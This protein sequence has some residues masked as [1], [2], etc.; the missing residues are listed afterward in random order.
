MAYHSDQLKHMVGQ[1]FNQRGEKMK[2]I[3]SLSL[4]IVLLAACN[5]LP[6]TPPTTPSTAAAFTR[7]PS[8]TYT[9]EPS[10][11]VLQEANGFPK[12][13][14]QTKR[15]GE[16][17]DN[18]IGLYLH[19]LPVGE[20]W[21]PTD[22]LNHEVFDLGVKRMK[23]AINELDIGMVK[24]STSEFQITPVQDELITSLANNGI[25]SSY[26]LSFWDKANHPT[27][28]TPVDSRFKT[29]TE[30]QRYLDFVRFIV[31]NVKG[32]VQYFEIWNEPDVGDL[33]QRIE[34]PEYINLVKHAIPV[35]HEEYPEAKIVISVAGTGDWASRD[36]LYKLIQSDEIMPLVDVV[37][38]H[39]FYDSSPEFETEYYYGYQDF[40]QYINNVA[41]NHGFRGEYWATEM[42]WRSPECSWCSADLPTYSNLV[43]AKYYARGIILNL[44]MDVTVGVGSMSAN[45]SSA[46][47][48][49]RNICTV[50]D[51]ADPVDIPHMIESEG[52][53]IKSFAF[54]LPNGD[55][56]VALWTDGAAIDYDPGVSATLTF[57]SSSAESVT[58]IDVLNGFTQELITET[59]NGNLVIRNLLI[60]D[61]PIILRFVRPNFAEPSTAEAT[62]VEPLESPVFPVSIKLRQNR[63]E[64]IPA[65]TP[66]QLTISLKTD[67]EEQLVDFLDAI[68]MNGTLDGQSLPDLNGYWGK[69]WP[70]ES[71]DAEQGVDYI[72]HW[73]HPLGVLSPGVHTIEIRGTLDLPVTDGYDRN[74][75]GQPDEYSGEIFRISMRIEIY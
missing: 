29:E 19:G 28:W 1:P 58:G 70:D 63:V 17:T 45:L 66:I 11:M 55:G 13:L 57:P 3:L 61:Y 14:I 40:V 5:S 15:S 32:R 50:M 42:D 53:N 30:V 36:Y 10:F 56:L 41:S 54:A 52:T 34:V 24:W 21:D 74:S 65:G 2:R 12:I 26:I 31:R 27:G 62:S 60:K 44:G 33:R 47:P 16:L 49:V 6:K 18:R 22:M 4:C 72:S 64:Q 35:I 59:E 43:A 71:G 20:S 75:D 67:I 8:A 73:L 37:S 48:T 39:P 9:S 69:I 7:I 68:N 25:I 46:F 23:F 51:T 38:W